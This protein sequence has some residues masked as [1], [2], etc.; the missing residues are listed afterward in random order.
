MP[1]RSRPAGRILAQCAAVLARRL[2][3]VPSP[4]PGQDP[5]E[6]GTAARWGL[7]PTGGLCHAGIARAAAAGQRTGGPL[8]RSSYVS[9]ADD[10]GPYRQVGTIRIPRP[11]AEDGIAQAPSGFRQAYGITRASSRDAVRMYCLRR[12]AGLRDRGCLARPS[13]RRCGSR[14]PRHDWSGVERRRRA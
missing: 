14:C 3:R 9:R 6:R 13:I 11:A 7:R 5:Q 10:P 1:G 2:R 8:R 12:L 4:V